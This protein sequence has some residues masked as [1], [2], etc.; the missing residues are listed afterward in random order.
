[1]LITEMLAGRRPRTTLGTQKW[2]WL[3]VDDV[4][5]AILATVSAPA[6]QGVF[7]LG[8]GRAVAVRT[9][10]DLIRDLAAPGMELMYGEVPFRPDQVMHMQANISRLTS[11]TGWMPRIPIEEGLTATVAWYRARAT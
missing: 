4:A 9:V 10:V 11:A 3:Y 6:A 2:D 1:M 7:N 8:S 5:R